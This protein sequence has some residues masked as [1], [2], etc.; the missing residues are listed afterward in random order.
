METRIVIADD[1]RLL[2]EALKT[3]LECH[4]ELKVVG[5]A[6]DGRMVHELVSTSQ[7]D[8]V[9]MDINMPGMNGVDATRRLLSDFPKLRV[10]ALSGCNHKQYVLEMLAAG[11]SAFVVKECVGD[12]LVRAILAVAKGQKYLCPEVSAAVVDHSGDYRA[13]SS[14]QL[15]PRERE[16]L[17]LLAEGST[18]VNIAKRLFISPSTVDVHRRNIMKKLDLHSVAELT[19]FAVRNGITSI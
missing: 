15:G 9:V 17:Q 18:S 6:T 8:V 19:K 10:V 11:A 4:K 14:I 3:M 2:L 5:T 1:H 7:P 13:G 12:E 16:V